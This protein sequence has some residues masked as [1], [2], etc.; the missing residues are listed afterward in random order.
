MKNA[1]V[2]EWWC[3]DLGQSD[4]IQA[5]VFDSLTSG[6][7]RFTPDVV[8][9]RNRIFLEMSRTKHLFKLDG[10]MKRAQALARRENLDSSL[11]RFGIAETLPKAWVQTRWRARDA[12]LLPVE[13]YFDFIDPLNH[14]ELSR[15]QRERLT[16][17]QSL[18]MKSL[19][20]LFTIP[21][22]AWLVRFGE[23]FDS[24]LESYEFGSRFLWNRF[25]PKIDLLEKT[26]WNA[27]EYVIDAEGLIF[28]L[29]PIVDRICSRLHALQRAIKKIEITLKLDR[30]VPDRIIELGFTFPQTS[31]TLLLK[32][33]RERI[34]REMERSPLSDPIVEA[35]VA[36]KESVKR[37]AVTERF[38]FSEQD[39]RGEQESE[40][41]MELVS[42]LGMKLEKEGRVYQAETTGH[43]LPERSW[44]KVLLPGAS[45]D[46]KLD[47]VSGNYAKRPLQLFRE[48]IPISRIGP[49]LKQNESLWRICSFSQE[50]RMEGY[51]WDVDDTG[52]FE[53]TYYRVRV[54]N[55]EGLTQDWWIFRDELLGKLN[56]HGVY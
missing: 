35:S 25:V 8:Q 16:V 47:A 22:E 13:S 6:F 30:P 27:E 36:I 37:A 14:F 45:V 42:Y 40:R 43:A 31:K 9:G 7:Y 20:Y 44:K 3:I 55:N 34:A 32:L 23:E 28:R 50:E 21:K 2:Q 26:R 24:F 52:G 29:K 53:R 5:E 48:P 41:W 17:F 12:R 19:E 11:W 33:L 1:G 10:F 54:K 46:L 51:E 18:G 49:Y 4:L 56:L 15:S 39:E 38:A